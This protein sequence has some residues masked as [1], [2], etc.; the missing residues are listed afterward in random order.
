MSS[1]TPLV[2]NP[3]L[4]RLL[5]ELE[6]LR[7]CL[8]SHEMYKQFRTL[9]DVH[10]FMEHHV[11]AVTDFM[12]LLK[13]LQQK[14]TCCAVPWRPTEHWLSRRVINEI[15]LEEESDQGPD[16]T[17]WSHF[18]M[19]RAAMAH[20]GANTKPV[21]D[22]LRCLKKGYSVE[23]A[24]AYARVPDA[25][26]VFLMRTWKLIQ[27]D[28]LPAIAA[29]FTLGREKVIPEMFIGIRDSLYQ[30]YP[31]ELAPLLEYLE[32]HITLDGE[33]H[34][35]A[36]LK[37][38]NEICHN[39]GRSWEAALSASRGALEARIQLW[40]AV[41]IAFPGDLVEMRRKP[42]ASHPVSA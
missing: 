31:E 12:W 17:Y 28:S 15:V 24:L 33:E 8:R 9:K 37:M 36:A 25:A 39:D 42:L 13:S 27:T 18:E 29:A 4:N 34:S 5:L 1:D 40:N 38:L 41:A 6:P 16:G 22:F 26:G 35:V 7:S 21:D 30:Q 2:H 32:R 14:L 23:G 10:A 3:A 11:F 20:A 19:Y